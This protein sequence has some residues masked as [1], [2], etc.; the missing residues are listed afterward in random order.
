MGFDYQEG[1]LHYSHPNFNGG[2]SAVGLQFDG[3]F[4]IVKEYDPTGHHAANVTEQ[5]QDNGGW[6][7][8]KHTSGQ[9]SALLVNGDGYEVALGD[10]VPVVKLN[11]TQVYP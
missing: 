5:P 4:P 1:K 10:G 7:T 8:R 2:S 6:V 9:N 11:G 3:V